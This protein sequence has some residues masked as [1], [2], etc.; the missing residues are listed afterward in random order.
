M[1]IISY[2]GPKKTAID[3]G[4]GSGVLSFQIIKH[5]FQKVFG[6]DTNPNAIFG[7]TEFMKDTKLSRK[8]DL[9]QEK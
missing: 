2:E 3:I 6:T 1:H 4:C 5:G 7:L 8:I 9:L